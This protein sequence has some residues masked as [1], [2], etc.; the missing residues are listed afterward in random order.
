VNIIFLLVCSTASGSLR[1]EINNGGCWKKTQDGRT[2]S[3]CVV[4]L[5]FDGNYPA[6][7]FLAHILNLIV[8]NV[9]YSLVL[10]WVSGR[11]FSRLQ[12][13]SGIQG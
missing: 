8:S 4:S 12:V 9:T 5:E 7:C 10:G 13:S 2:F 3:A 11:S 1:C 6:Y